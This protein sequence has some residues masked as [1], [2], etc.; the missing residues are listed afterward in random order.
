MNILLNSSIKRL[1][2]NII[3]KIKQYR[4]DKLN[5]KLSYHFKRESQELFHRIATLFNQ[6]NIVFWLEYGSLLGYYREHDYLKNDDDF[7][8]GAYLKDATQIR[9]ILLSNG[10]EIVRYYHDLNCGGIEE[11]YRYGQMHTTFDIFYFSAVNDKLLTTGFKSILNMNMRKNLRK[12]VPFC[13][14]Q[15]VFPYTEFEMVTYKGERV[16]VPVN[17]YEH[18]AAHY[19]PDFMIPQQHFN[20][21]TAYNVTLLPYDERPAIGWMKYGYYDLA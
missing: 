16:Y 5:A 15:I 20:N 11:C 4:T 13:V 3:R 12:E 9:E 18:L 14:R 8:F 10:F 19:G 2:G 21:N 7:D 1:I 17:V 6:N